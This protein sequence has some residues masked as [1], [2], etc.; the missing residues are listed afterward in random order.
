MTVISYQSKLVLRILKAGE[1]YRAKP[2]L[3]LRGEYN[4]MIDL[5]GLHCECPIFGVLKGKKQNTGGKVSGSVRLVLDVPDKSVS[6]THLDVY[7]R[8]VQAG[9]G[10]V[11]GQNEGL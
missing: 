11:P 10:A 2:N 8:Q 4:A 6:Y 7:K 1:T 5:L 3:T 9:G